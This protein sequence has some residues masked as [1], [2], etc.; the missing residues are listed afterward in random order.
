M[1]PLHPH[2]AKTKITARVPVMRSTKKGNTVT[3]A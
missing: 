2:Q 1:L 3:L